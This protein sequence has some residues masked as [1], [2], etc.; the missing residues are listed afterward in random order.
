[1][2]P[3]LAALSVVC[4]SAAGDGDAKHA[5]GVLSGTLTAAPAQVVVGVRQVTTDVYNG[6]YMPPL[7]RVQPGDTIALRL[8]NASSEHTNIHY[9]GLAVTPLGNGDNGFLRRAREN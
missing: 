2:A 3:A 4:Q 5:G 9:H 1:V 8:Q 7:L 6:L